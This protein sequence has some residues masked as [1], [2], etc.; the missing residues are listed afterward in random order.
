M[1]SGVLLVNKQKGKTSHDI[2]NRA[3]RLLGERSIGHTGTL[4]PLATGLLVLILGEVTKLS[5][6]LMD[7]NKA[8]KVKI[9]FGVVTDSW[10]ITGKV[11]KEEKASV[12]KEQ[13]LKVAETLMGEVELKVPAFSAIKV[14]GKKLYESAHKNIETPDVFRKMNFWNLEVI[15]FQ[16]TS[17]VIHFECS[18]GAYVRS[19]VQEL[20][21]RLGCGATVEE[22]ERDINRPFN[23]ENSITLESQTRDEILSS[24]AYVSIHKML[25]DWPRVSVEGMD[26]QL[27]KNGQLTTRTQLSILRATAKSQIGETAYAF[28]VDPDQNPICFVEVDSYKK[29]HF[30]RGFQG[31]TQ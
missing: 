22:L 11:L 3:R 6:V 18:K 13:F 23:L 2:V 4:D 26:L 9:K 5:A 12:A 14:D 19:W 20:G 10:D 30:K 29:I 1:I 16:E 25:P 24:G 31:L 17:A 7:G 27:I 28:I 8:Y 15:D 21:T